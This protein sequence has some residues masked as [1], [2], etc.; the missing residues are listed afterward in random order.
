MQQVVYITGNNIKFQQART[1]CEIFGIGIEQARLDIPEIQSASGEVVAR[2]KAEQA[3]ALHGKPL[4][5][6][7]DSWMIPGLKNFPGPYMKYMNDWF[8]SDDWLRLTK[9]LKDRRIILR[10]IVVYQEANFQKIFSA[11]IPGVLLT[12]A[13]GKSP[14]SHTTI[15]SFDN[16]RH[17]SAEFH[18][19]GESGVQHVHNPWHDFA[20]WYIKERT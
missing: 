11:D 14:Y 10:Q 12:K 3:F 5:V 4:V 16:G 8:D 9:D 7:D 17:S 2:S 15:T 13:S 19:R 1:A 18:E 6:S 20:R